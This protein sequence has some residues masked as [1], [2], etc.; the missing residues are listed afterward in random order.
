MLIDAPVVS[1]P[2]DDVQTPTPIAGI[3]VRISG[4]AWSGSS[5]SSRS[6]RGRGAHARNSPRSS[7]C[8][9]TVVTSALAANHTSSAICSAS[10]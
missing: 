9:T 7:V 10:R 6:A 8:V 4:N 3:L 5:T 2:V 1:D